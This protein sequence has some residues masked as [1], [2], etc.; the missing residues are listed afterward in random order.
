MGP[1][2]GIHWHMALSHTIDYVAADR[3]RQDIPW[4]RTTDSS[5]GRETVYRSDGKPVNDPMPEGELRRIDCVDC[6]NR[7]THII[8]PPDR[9][10]NASMET[11]RMDRTLPYLKKAAV[12]ALVGNYANETE[13]DAGIESALRGFYARLDPKISEERKD[14]I[15]T[16][17]RETRAI[18]HRNFFPR[19]RVSWKAYRDNIGHM[20][21]DGCFRCHDG[22]HVNERQEPISRNCHICHDFLQPAAAVQG[23][24]A[25]VQGVP[26]H[27][28]KLEGKHATLNCSACHTGGPG[29]ERTCAGCHTTQTLFRQGKSPVLPGLQGT[30]PSVMAD[31]DCDAC[32]DLSKPQ[33]TANIA[34]Q[35]VSCHDKSYADMIQM[36][37]DDAAAGRAK[38]M[39]AIQKLDSSTALSAQMR[40]ALAQVDHAVPVHNTDFADA[41]YQ[42]IVKLAAEKK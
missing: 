20:L 8:Q 18:Y 17:I 13:A 11:G 37:K 42:Q 41:I 39:E 32:H 14:S 9:A 36:W 21:F 2:S 22:R 16:A 15:N 12:E 24:P 31:L 40:D 33:T 6:H 34:I 35:C 29:P 25:Y 30:P 27:P 1:A 4:V 19:M 38:A 10:V 5:T 3:E 23:G 7:P 26:E 28:L